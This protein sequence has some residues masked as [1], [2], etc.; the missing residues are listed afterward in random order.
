MCDMWCHKAYT[1]KNEKQV[2]CYV[3]L[4]GV[5]TFS[6]TQERYYTLSDLFV[7]LKM[8]LFFLTFELQMRFSMVA[9]S[10]YLF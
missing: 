2:G 10:I 9:K 6:Y 3:T 7:L 5:D 4:D 1:D 8:Y